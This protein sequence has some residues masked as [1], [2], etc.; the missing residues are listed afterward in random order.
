MHRAFCHYL[1]K[2]YRIE[3][4]Q[5]RPCCFF[6]GSIDINDPDALVSYTEYVHS[7]N[8]WVPS[9]NFCKVREVAGLKSP[10]QLMQDDP[11]FL[12]TDQDIVSLQIQFDNICNA[13]CLICGP[14]QSTTW[15]KYSNNIS[16]NK[17]HKVINITSETQQLMASD[18]LDKLKRIVD[19]SK[20]KRI[21]FLGGEPLLTNIH[22][23]FANEIPNPEKVVLIY[24]TNVSCKPSE[25]MLNLWRK[26][27]QV[28]LMVSIDGTDTHHQYLRWP[29]RWDTLESNLKFI[30]EQ[31][32]INFYVCGSY[33]LTP[34]SAFYHDRYVD[35]ARNF[36]KDTTVDY[37]QIFAHPWTD[38]GGMMSIAATPQTLIDEIKSKYG[39]GHVISN[40]MEPHDPEKYK[41]F[42]NYINYH[43]EHRKLNW[44]EVFP[45]IQHHFK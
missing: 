13:A 24:T 37:S 5:L 28:K 20:L 23:D 1:S 10:R 12:Q 7:V 34:F 31:P 15:A 19:F 11:A 35:W 43:D 27:K 39:D 4:D 40:I 2:Q 30:V 3:G 22:E 6:D 36:F 44:R 9:C 18:Y 38:R 21:E 33:T 29:M 17:T 45:E 14:A 42:V 26:F 41:Q 16:Q 8:D 25:S 32:S